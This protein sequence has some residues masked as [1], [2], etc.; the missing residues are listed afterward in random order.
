MADMKTLT[1]NGV[2]YNI[3]D[4]GAVQTPETAE[5]GQTI[6][7][8]SVDANGKPTAWECVDLPSDDHINALI[9]EKLGDIETALNSI[10]EIQNSL[11]GGDGA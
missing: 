7:V 4:D 9:D 10:I 3:K 8:K 1:I 2:I 11:I 5:A 6:V